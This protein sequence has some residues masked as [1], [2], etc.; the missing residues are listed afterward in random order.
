MTTLAQE[1]HLG[2]PCPATDVAAPIVLPASHA[3]VNVMT[4]DVEDHFQ[5]SAFDSTVSRDLWPAFES[6]V[7][8]NTERFLEI[9]ERARV[10]ATFFVLG[11]TA[12][13]CPQI[14]R[15][16]RS[17]GQELASH[18]YDHRLVYTL[19]PEEFRKD[20]RKAAAAIE[21]RLVSSP[22]PLT[23][24]LPRRSWVVNLQT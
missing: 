13:H 14:V 7:A 10:T 9:P 5:V 21:G 20:L 19:T 11:W 24:C 4:V 12:E 15:A 23:A 22:G 18:S 2:A 3:P 16:I 1:R 6:R 8:R 17:G